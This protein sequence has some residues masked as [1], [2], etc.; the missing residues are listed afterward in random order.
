MSD[1][2][3]IPGPG[4]QHAWAGPESSELISRP[5]LDYPIGENNDNYL[6]PPAGSGF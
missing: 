3:T 4:L 1:P 5:S 2:T 6:E